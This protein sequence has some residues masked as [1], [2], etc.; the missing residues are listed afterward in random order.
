MPFQSRG[1]FAQINLKKSTR[2]MNMKS[3]TIQA[4]L[5]L[6]VAASLLMPLAMLNSCGKMN[7]RANNATRKMQFTYGFTVKNIPAGASQI[8][9]WAPA[10]QSDD[11]QTITGLDVKCSYPY[12]FE[13]EPEYGN[14]ILHVQGNGALPESL[15]VAMNFA[16]TRNGYHILQNKD[17]GASQMTDAILQRS[18]APDRLVP[19]DGKVEDELNKV[20]RDNMAPLDKARAIYDHVV[21]TMTYDKSGTGWGRGDVNYACDVRKGNCTDF[22]SLFI[23]M[24]RAS[25]IPARFVIGF[26]VPENVTEGTIP[27]Y[28]CWAEFYIEGIGWLPVD[29]SEASK[30]REKTNDLFGGLDAH[31]VQF[32]VGRDIRVASMGPEAEPLNYFIYPQ[33]RIDGKAHGDIVRQVRFA[34]L[35]N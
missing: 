33:V 29:A 5:T 2:M 16:V 25:K 19:L 3:K 11:R 14:S 34:E 12:S 31:R 6:G 9:I 23:G 15:E 1:F 22:H 26:P 10:P 32:T 28:H 20:V 18:L 35:A 13:N 27:G 21:A 7:A 8:D 17:K 24:N 4:F 30:N